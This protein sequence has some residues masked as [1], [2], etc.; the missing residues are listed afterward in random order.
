MLKV[1][2]LLGILEVQLIQRL[3]GFH[4]GSLEPALDLQVSELSGFHRPEVGF[5]Y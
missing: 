2:K 3:S 4:R 5:A 1:C